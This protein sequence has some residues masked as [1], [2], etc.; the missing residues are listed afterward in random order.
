MTKGD[1][2][3]QYYVDDDGAM[4]REKI[5]TFLLSVLLSVQQKI[6]ESRARFSHP[7]II[8]VY[9]KSNMRFDLYLRQSK[10]LI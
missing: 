9:F 5:I 6:C 8:A 4:K 3:N 1:G 2:K 10:R 7:V